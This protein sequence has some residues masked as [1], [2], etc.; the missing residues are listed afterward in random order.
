MPR[1]AVPVYERIIHIL[2]LFGV[3]SFLYRHLSPHDNTAPSV[4]QAPAERADKEPPKGHE[5]LYCQISSHDAAALSVGRGPAE[6]KADKK[7]PLKSHEDQESAITGSKPREMAV[8]ILDWIKA[9]CSGRLSYAQSV[10]DG[11]VSLEKMEEVDE[12]KNGA[13]IVLR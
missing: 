2:I 5:R 8:E 12:T 6:Q 9:L 3:A 10:L 11:N 13:T 7:P 1:R 4:D